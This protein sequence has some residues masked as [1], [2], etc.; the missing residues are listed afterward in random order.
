MFSSI[1]SISYIG[2]AALTVI[3]CLLTWHLWQKRPKKSAPGTNGLPLVGVLFSLGKYTERTMTKWAKQYGPLYMIKVGPMDVVVITCPDIAYEAFAKCEFFND[4]PQ[5]IALL[6]GSKG[7]LFVNKTDLHKEQRRF[8][9]NTLRLFG[10]GR[11]TL[12][13]RLIEL[14]DNLCSK[15]D[16]LS[17]Q[18]IEMK[19]MIFELVSSVISCMIFGYDI[20]VEDEVFAQFLKRLS[21]TSTVGFLVAIMMFAPFLKYVFPFSY[22]WNRGQRF[23]KVFHKEIEREIKKHVESMDIHNPRDYIDCFLIEMQKLKQG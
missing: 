10:M 11:R 9:L 6:S 15:I 16:D 12:E 20:T 7:I 8:G 2:T 4:R 1:F 22:V 21:G 3:I 14:T 13:P 23:Q 18:P 5:S 17:D 19:K